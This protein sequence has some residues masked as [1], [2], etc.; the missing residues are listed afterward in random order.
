M[1]VSPGWHS[2][3]ERHLAVRKGVQVGLLESPYCAQLLLLLLPHPGNSRHFSSLGGLSLF[4]LVTAHSCAL[5]T[6]PVAVNPSPK[7][8]H[9]ASRS[10]HQPFHFETSSWRFSFIR[11]FRFSA[12]PSQWPHHHRCRWLPHHTRQASADGGVWSG[13]ENRNFPRRDQERWH[14]PRD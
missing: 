6:G 9:L 1:V 12:Q 7:G 11:R 5:D 2:I 3:A 14:H 13:C 4:F 8:Y 10:S